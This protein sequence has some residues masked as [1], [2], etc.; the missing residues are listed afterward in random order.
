MNTQKND[1]EDLPT[2]VPVSVPEL[3]R[4][5]TRLVF[6]LCHLPDFIWHWS[7][8]RRHKQ[9]LAKRAH[10]KKRGLMLEYY[11]RL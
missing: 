4:L 9:W 5:F 11:L 10:Y 8:W 3:R 7:L 1:W 6:S 2:H